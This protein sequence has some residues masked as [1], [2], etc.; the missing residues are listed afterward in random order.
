MLDPLYALVGVTISFIHDQLTS[1]GLAGAAGYT[2]AISIVLL[3][4][5]VRIL[6]FPLFV[7]QIRSQRAQQKLMPQIKEL[8]TKYAGDRQALGQETMKLYKEQGVNPLSGCFPILL[9]APVFI[10]LYGVLTRLRPGGSVPG[11]PGESVN[12]AAIA[13]LFDGVPIAAGFGPRHTTGLDAADY[14]GVAINLTTGLLIL[15]MGATTYLAAR[16]MMKRSAAQMGQSGYTTQQKVLLYA[17]P[18]MLLVFGFAI[19]FPLGVLI[20][21]LTSNLWTLGQQHFVIGR[22]D[23]ADAEKAEAERIRREAEAEER[24]RNRPEGVL[25]EGLKPGE[26]G[27]QRRQPQKK[28]SSNKSKGRR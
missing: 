2:W 3:T 22:M 16:Q 9:Q 15:L 6:I 21:M 17:M 28:K 26:T 19:G 24:R 20:Y 8:Q 5:C 4:I 12:Q 18:I 7:K 23:K 25:A 13:Q 11:M 1:L 10:A 27:R 14:S